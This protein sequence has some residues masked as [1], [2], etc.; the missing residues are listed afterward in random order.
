MIRNVKVIFCDN[1]H[2]FG[3]VTFPRIDELTD[4]DFISP[5]TTKQLRVEAK[6]AGWTRIRKSGDYCDMCSSQG[7]P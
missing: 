5:R 7:Q 6:K 4:E 2:G 3:N 1:E